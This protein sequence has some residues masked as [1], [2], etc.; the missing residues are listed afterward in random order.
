MHILINLLANNRLAKNFI[1]FK[2]NS[3]N[4]FLSRIIYM[5][6][7]QFQGCLNHF[8]KMIML[9]LCEKTNLQYSLYV[10][11]YF[12]SLSSSL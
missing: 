8:I 12:F 3:S 10:F 6:H 2:K 7:K 4:L 5:M 9:F 11:C 1:F